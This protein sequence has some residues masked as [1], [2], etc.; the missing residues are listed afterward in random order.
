MIHQDVN[1]RQNQVRVLRKNGKVVVE[2]EEMYGTSK[3]NVLVQS[4]A[5][6]RRVAVKMLV[7]AQRLEDRGE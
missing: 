4:P 1:G 6:A 5:D 3:R 7:A 2:V